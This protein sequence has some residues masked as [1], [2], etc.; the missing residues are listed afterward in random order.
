MYELFIDVDSERL[1]WISI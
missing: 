1:E